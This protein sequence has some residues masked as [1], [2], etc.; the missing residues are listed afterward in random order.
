MRAE[1]RRRN[2]QMRQRERAAYRDRNM[3]ASY[4]EDED[5]IEQES[6]SA[7]KKNVKNKKLQGE[8]FLLILDL[9]E[10]DSFI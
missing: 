6:I 1:E 5:D 8:I 9:K 2:Q 4:L 10:M 7:I 3:S